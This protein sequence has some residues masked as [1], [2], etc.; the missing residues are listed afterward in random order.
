MSDCT[1]DVRGTCTLEIVGARPRPEEGS[2]L[3][4]PVGLRLAPG[5]LAL[6]DAPDRALARA[7][8]EL[9]AGLPALAGGVVRFLGR[10]W[11]ALS[12]REA[13]ALRGRIGL[14]PDDGGW[15][16]HLSVAEGMLLAARHHGIEDAGPLERR[17]D[18]LARHFGLDGVPEETPHE[19]SRL[20]LARAGCARAFLQRP[21]LLLLESP[22][23]IEAADALVEPLRA[24]LEPAL[25]EGVTAVWA[26]RSRIAWEDPSFP[27][28]RRF[29]LGA[30]GLV[31]A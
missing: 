8:A 16:P 23:E 27:A 9:C 5:E 28:T 22:R 29:H 20:D 10:D 12:R 31:A 17:A 6:V 24:L 26:T 19:L 14:A 15:L 21:A 30:G 7:L 25:A 4:G 18:A 11:T 13:E 1:L 3:A 2:P